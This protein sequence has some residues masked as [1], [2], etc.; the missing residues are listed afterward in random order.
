MILLMRRKSRKSYVSP[1]TT[2]IELKTDGILLGSNDPLNALLFFGE[3]FITP[4]NG[5][6]EDW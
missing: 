6:G 5:G 3:D 2:S 4:F 1:E